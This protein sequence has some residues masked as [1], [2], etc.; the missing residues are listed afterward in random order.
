ME[1]ISRT[2]FRVPSNANA[3]FQLHIVNTKC[4]HSQSGSQIDQ[5]CRPEIIFVYKL[6]QA[7]A[8]RSTTGVP[9]I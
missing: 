4:P 5:H 7:E 3:P 9:Y 2:A 1:S 8:S 6:H